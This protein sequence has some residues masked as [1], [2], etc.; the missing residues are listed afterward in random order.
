MDSKAHTNSIEQLTGLLVSV[1]QSQDKSVL[2]LLTELMEE[3][4]EDMELSKIA[5]E[6]YK[7]KRVKHQDAFWD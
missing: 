5:D 7:E 3:E 1:A 4:I 2:K 6:R